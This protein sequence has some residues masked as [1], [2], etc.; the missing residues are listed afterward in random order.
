[1]ADLTFVQGDTAPSVF[2][3]LTDTNGD[4][5]DLT[6]CTV[7]FQMRNTLDRRFV[8]NAVAV[9]E[10]PATGGEVRYDWQAGDLSEVGSFVSRWR[11]TFGDST[12]EHTD[13]EN[14]IT[15]AAQ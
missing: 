2:G 13:P 1:M 8:V 3:T 9:I 6:G 15:V 11:I 4:P 7:R 12:I 10:S 14:T 5:I